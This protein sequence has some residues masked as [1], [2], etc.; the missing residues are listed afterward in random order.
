MW[1]A[2]CCQVA[3]WRWVNSGAILAT[4]MTSD[5]NDH[6]GQKSSRCCSQYI[7]GQCL[8]PLHCQLLSLIQLVLCFL[9]SRR[10]L[11]STGSG[12]SARHVEPFSGAQHHS[13]TCW[14]AACIVL[15][16]FR[17]TN[18]DVIWIGHVVR[19][20]LSGRLKVLGEFRRNFGNL[21]DVRWQWSLRAKWPSG[22][23]L[24]ACIV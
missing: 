6:L 17:I 24:Q 22:Q 19:S 2:V 15:R 9:L 23:A 4:W 12:V 5:D 8:L 13:L 3:W 16:Q 14:E 21:D 18:E 7:T 11:L 1:C 10:R 20:V